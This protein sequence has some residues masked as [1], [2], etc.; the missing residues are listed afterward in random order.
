MKIILK[1]GVFIFNII[2]FFIK[3]FPVQNKIVFI[4]RQANKPSIDFKLLGNKLDKKMD[5]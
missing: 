4:S 1:I 5:S 3:L 2:Y